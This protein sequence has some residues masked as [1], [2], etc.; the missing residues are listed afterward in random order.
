MSTLW[1]VARVMSSIATPLNWGLARRSACTVDSA[2]VFSVIAHFQRFLLGVKSSTIDQTIE[3][4][5]PF[6]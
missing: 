4:S 1:P 3:R 6:V 5:S 2:V